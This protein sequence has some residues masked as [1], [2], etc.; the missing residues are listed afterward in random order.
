MTLPRQKNADQSGGLRL[1]DIPF[2]ETMPEEPAAP[3]VPGIFGPAGD[4]RTA[5]RRYWITHPVDGLLNTVFHGLLERLPARFVSTFGN[6]TADLARLRYKNR[7]FAGRIERNFHALTSSLDRNDQEQQDG[8]KRWW[9]NIGRTMAEFSKANHLWREDHLKVQGLEN[10]ERAQEL[11][12]PLIFVSMHLGTWEAAFT[13][14]HEGLAAP[15]IGPFQP[16]PN[17]FTNRI[18][19]KLRKRRNQYLFP[20]GQRSAIRLHKLLRSGAASLTIFIDEVRDNQVHLPAFGRP[21]PDKGNAVVAIKLANAAGGTIVPF[22]LR[23]Q[24][25]P[26]FD[27]NILP[28]LEPNA[29][30][31]TKRYDLRPTLQAFNEIFEPI[32]LDNIEHW[33]MLGELRLPANFERNLGEKCPTALS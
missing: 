28:P 8:L 31:Q 14:I 22:Y 10:L 25:G 2:H 32:V 5:A 24:N 18:V 4:E 9:R 15:S 20:P 23:R 11:G 16:E 33:Y 17:R 26:D 3:S 12:K 27:L 21:L 19:Y 30:Y 29:A 13:A 7:I 6:A 1:E